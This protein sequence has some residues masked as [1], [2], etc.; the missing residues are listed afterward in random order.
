VEERRGVPHHLID[1]AE[2]DQVW[3]LTLFQEAARQVIANIH[4]RERLPLLVGGTGQYVRAV[5]EGW[6][7]PELP[8]NPALRSAIERWGQEIGAQA[9]HRRLGMIDPQAAEVIQYQNVRRTVRA[10]EVIF[11]TGRRFS[12]QRGRSASPYSLLTI[13]LT[14]PRPELYERIDAR[15]QLMLEL[16]LVDEVRRLLEQGYSPDLPTM[17][18]IG[19][20]EISAY[21]QGKMSLD[22][23][24]VQ[25][26][27]LTRQFVRRQANW[28]KADDP[29]IH[30][31][32]SQPGL[33]EKVEA[34]ICSGAAWVTPEDKKQTS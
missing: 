1:V 27:R 17:T 20:R 4:N 18:A 33:A 3:S 6:T 16:G 22:E 19:Y 2:P 9:L 5:T 12:E 21:L 25:M 24:V 7:P 23:A 32:Q 14:R 31:F 29:S 10:L 11:S 28:F 15:I 13:G 30:W 8:P 34:L 26:K